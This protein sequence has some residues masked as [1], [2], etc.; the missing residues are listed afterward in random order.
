MTYDVLNPN[1]VVT[2]QRANTGRNAILTFKFESCTSE[3][4]I[5][6]IVVIVVT[7]VTVVI[8]VIVVVSRDFVTI[9]K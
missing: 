9:D 6:V 5:V 3:E 2:P 4:Y 1:S 7:V 8:V